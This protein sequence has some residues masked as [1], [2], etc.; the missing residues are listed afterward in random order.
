MA[1][2]LQVIAHTLQALEPKPGTAEHVCDG[3]WACHF[4]DVQIAALQPRVVIERNP[5]D[6][7]DVCGTEDKFGDFQLTY[8]NGH[9]IALCRDC[10]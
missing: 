3:G 10:K 2:E 8:R 6:F 5:L 9:Q 1:A 4:H 7:C